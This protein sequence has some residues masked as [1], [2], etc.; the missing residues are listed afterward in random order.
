MIKLFFINILV[1][2][3]FLSCENNN[4]KSETL[5]TKEIKKTQ[6]TDQ[7]EDSVRNKIVDNRDTISSLKIYFEHFS[8]YK[9]SISELE[10]F[11]HFPNTFDKFQKLYGFN[12]QEGAMP[13]YHYYHIGEYNE[14]RKYIKDND[15]FDKLIS[16]GISGKWD[17]D[18]IS[19][20]QEVIQSNLKKN[21]ISF[22]KE[23]NRFSPNDQINFWKF[24]FDTPE[25]NHPLYKDMINETLY[26]LKTNKYHLIDKVNSIIE[27]INREGLH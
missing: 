7:I 9:D 26:I 21:P 18:N 3:F 10:F 15:Y 11:K 6:K 14:I 2:V 5:T 23:M 17:A 1:F 24:Y 25:P 4:K 13:L 22:M 27:N 12:D 16:I 20:L 8:K 19:S